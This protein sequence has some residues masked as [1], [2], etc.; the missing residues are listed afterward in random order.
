M[1]KL[2]TRRKYIFIYVL[3]VSY[4]NLQPQVLAQEYHYKPD[5]IITY[6][7]IGTDTFQKK[8]IQKI[9]YKYNPQ[10][11]LIE[12]NN[13]NWDNTTLKWVNSTRSIYK[14]ISNDVYEEHYNMFNDS[15]KYESR[16][17]YQFKKPL[18]LIEKTHEKKQQNETIVLSK[19]KFFY[20]NDTLL[21]IERYKRSTTFYQYNIV[22]YK[23]NYNVETEI[24]TNYSEVGQNI[25][26]KLIHKKEY[27]GVLV[28][29]NQ[30]THDPALKR[31]SSVSYKYDKENRLIADTLK[32]ISTTK[33]KEKYLTLTQYFYDNTMHLNSLIISNLTDHQKIDLKKT[34]TLIKYY[35]KP[36]SPIYLKKPSD[37]IIE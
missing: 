14:M 15:I 7:Y 4:F 16:E 6:S 3:I 12:K 28:K 9:T 5:S 27:K 37:Y 20:K 33:E 2:L 22:E 11:A 30:T 8:P 24:S 10:Y 34:N 23:W 35:Y 31:A 26:D 13:F 21:K 25:I 1:F 29:S 19:E 17:I 18:Q 36:T 32:L